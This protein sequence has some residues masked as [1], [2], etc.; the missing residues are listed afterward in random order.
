MYAAAGTIGSC[1]TA[2]D[3]RSPEIALE[4]PVKQL[5]AGM[6]SKVRLLPIIAMEFFDSLLAKEPPPVTDRQI[7]VNFIGLVDY[8]KDVLARMHRRAAARRIVD[9]EGVRQ[10]SRAEPQCAPGILYREPLSIPDL[11]LPLGYG[12]Y[13]FRDYEAML[14]C[15]CW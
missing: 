5:D 3:S 13:A 15:R 8:P 7:D 11:R 9:M 10:P 14:A 4:L 6:C 12:E 2:T 1:W